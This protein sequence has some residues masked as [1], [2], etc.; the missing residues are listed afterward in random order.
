MTVTVVRY[1]TKPERAEENQQLVERV[2]AAL[3]DSRPDG[4]HYMTVRLA[5][6]VSFV[7]IAS[8]ET[9]DGT[10]PLTTTPAFAEF[11]ADIGARLEEGPVV[12]EGTVIGSY[13]FPVDAVRAEGRP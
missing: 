8:V 9:A 11:Q 12:V 13:E 6:G 4:F 2:Y 10:N 3:A 1:R 5:D 7:H